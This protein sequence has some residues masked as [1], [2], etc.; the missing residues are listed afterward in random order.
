MYKYTYKVNC[1][2]FVKKKQPYIWVFFL[3]MRKDEA[4]SRLIQKFK[5]KYLCLCCIR[6]IR[7]N[8]HFDSSLWI[9]FYRIR[10]C[11]IQFCNLRYRTAVVKTNPSYPLINC[12]LANRNSTGLKYYHKN[13]TQ[14]AY[15]LISTNINGLYTR[16]DGETFAF[17]FDNTL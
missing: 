12:G 8:F 14:H 10:F 9:W 1:K 4:N 2:L 5:L 17:W 7:I 6:Q 15:K 11:R 16:C 3:I 13:S